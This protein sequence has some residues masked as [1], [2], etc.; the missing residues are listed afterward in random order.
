[1]ATLPAI[2]STESDTLSCPSDTVRER[3]NR[4]G[5]LGAFQVVLV[6]LESRKCPPVAD[7]RTVSTSR[8]GSLTRAAA[9][10]SPFRITD[11]GDTLTETIRGG[12]LPPSVGA[13]SPHPTRVDAPSKQTPARLHRPCITR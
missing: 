7:Q 5:A 4:P 11:P 3:V 13:L 6:L 2:T 1:M 8:S 12:E 9:L 10:A